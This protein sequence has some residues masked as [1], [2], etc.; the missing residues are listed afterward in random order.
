MPSLTQWLS[1]LNSPNFCDAPV[2]PAAHPQDPWIQ[3]ATLRNNVLMGHH[4]SPE[5]YQRAIDAACLEQDLQ[6]SGHS[7][8]QHAFLHEGV[9][10]SNAY[11][12]VAACPMIIELSLQRVGHTVGFHCNLHE[13]AYPCIPMRPNKC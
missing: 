1:V 2:D 10:P 8:A 13:H 11:C 4:Y 3:N 12:Y 9:R 7:T 6:V 5:R